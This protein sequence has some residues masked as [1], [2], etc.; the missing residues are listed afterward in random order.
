ML[1]AQG[2]RVDKT[3]SASA[4]VD[5]QAKTANENSNAVAGYYISSHRP[6]AP[7]RVASTSERHVDAD[8]GN[9]HA[10]QPDAAAGADHAVARQRAA[11]AGLSLISGLMLFRPAGLWPAHDHDAGQR[12]AVRKITR[13]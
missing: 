2:Y 6:V 8:P 11:A 9:L 3:A 10:S 12:P 4:M 13:S 7:G 5:I 1:D